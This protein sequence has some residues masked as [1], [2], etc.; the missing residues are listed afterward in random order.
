MFKNTWDV[1][2]DYVS[3]VLI[4]VGAISLSVRL[5]TTL[6]TGD[7]SCII[8]GASSEGVNISSISGLGP[9]PRGGA[10]AM[11][12]Y[13]QTHPN[14]IRAVF[15]SLGEYLPYIML[16]ETLILI[17]ARHITIKGGIKKTYGQ[18]WAHCP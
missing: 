2:E 5:L 12:N 11:V 17:V 4:S 7:V 18:L 16:L 6:G 13:A 8:T 3:Y 10:T 14:C 9:Y 15:T 1:I